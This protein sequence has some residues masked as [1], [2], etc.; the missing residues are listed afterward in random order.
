MAFFDCKP[1]QATSHSPCSLDFSTLAFG[2]WLSLSFL[3]G[4]HC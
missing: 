4:T 3:L 1:L 2:L